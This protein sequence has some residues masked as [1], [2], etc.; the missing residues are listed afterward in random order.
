M[1]P[2]LENPTCQPDGIADPLDSG[3]GAGLQRMA[4]HKNGV[5]L[6]IAVA[7]EVS[8]D[9]GIEYR[10]VL[11]LDNS[12][13]AGVHCRPAGFENGPAFGQSPLGSGSCRS[14]Y[15]GT[16]DSRAAMDKKGKIT[17]RRSITR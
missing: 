9:T 8:A 11:K 4:V 13:L 6:G 12:L 16:D 17:H 7:I 1:L 15:F 5:K 3:Y 10:I 14:L 2:F